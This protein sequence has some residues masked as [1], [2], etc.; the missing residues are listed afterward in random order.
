MRPVTACPT[1]GGKCGNWQYA[2]PLMKPSFLGRT[3]NR[4]IAFARVHASNRRRASKPSADCPSVDIRLCFKP[5]MAKAIALPRPHSPQCLQMNRHKNHATCTVS[6]STYQILRSFSGKAEESPAIWL[7]PTIS[8]HLER[9][10]LRLGYFF[11]WRSYHKM[12]SGE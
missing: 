5:G 8:P 11:P 4:S 3:L 10:I 6:Q 12:A 9:K 2:L 7:P 1:I